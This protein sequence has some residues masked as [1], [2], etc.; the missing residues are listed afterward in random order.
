MQPFVN[1]WKIRWIIP[2]LILV[3]ASCSD[4]KPDITDPAEAWSFVVFSDIQQ[5]Y[6]VYRQLAK[7]IGD[8]SPLPVL[9]V[10]CGDLMLRPNN[11]AEWVTFKNYSEPI[12]SRMPLMIIR[13]NHEGND[14]V[15]EQFL[16]EMWDFPPDCFYYS[17]RKEDA[18]FIILDTQISGEERG[19]LNQQLAW[20]EDRLDSASSDPGIQAIFI[21]THQP[22]YPQGLHKGNDLVN[23]DELHLLFLAHPRIRAVFSGHDHFFNC[24]QK[25]GIPYITTGGGGGDLFHGAGGDYFHFVKVSY[26]M[27]RLKFTLKTVDLFNEIIDSFDL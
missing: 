22:L 13:G 26:N 3:L 21:F 1:T 9:A 2:A 4:K 27:D 17:V 24:F 14:P 25:D 6:G 15:S 19:I 16:R 8:L 23:A 5:G 20:L 11:E 12:T 18:L 10:C 7:N